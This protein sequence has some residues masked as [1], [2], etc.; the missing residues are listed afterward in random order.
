[1]FDV[2]V[3]DPVHSQEEDEHGAGWTGV[4]MTLLLTHD[5]VRASVDMRDAI[6]AME[7]GYQEQANGGVV[8]PQRLN[9][10]AGKGWLRLGP[11]ILEQS[12]FMGFKAMNL[13]GGH[14]LRYQVH[15]YAISTGELLA[16]MDAQ[17]LTT[18][19]TG[20]TSAVAT[21]RLANPG[22]T[23]VGLIGSGAEAKTQAEA[24][25][26]LGV[27]KSLRV[28]SRTPE[29]RE[30]LAREAAEAW[31][32]EA[33]AVADARE[34]V[35]GCGIVLAAVKSSQTALEGAWLAPGTHVNSVGTARP[36]QREIDPETFT[37]AA[38]VVVDTKEG[39]FGEAGD[40]LAAKDVFTAEQ[41]HDLADLM[42]GR[43]PTR[44][45]AEQI[46]LFKSVGTAVQDIALAA[47]I[48]QKAKERGVGRD[49]G[50][51]PMLKGA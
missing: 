17:Y 39:V 40:A 25:W 32:V 35:D 31:G 9:V 50:E 42:G 14:G 26:A 44:T 21:R 20:A 7:D 1:M 8:M 12:G 22:E 28:Y 46:T 51:F 11:A 24:M 19:R 10:K 3:T 6:Q 33:Q 23:V 47:R 41:A 18:L 38:V 45:S 43:A 34:A 27:M 37:R 13:A 48:Y 5:E 4:P 15:L 49:V 30:R 29:N 36:D 16:I 2:L